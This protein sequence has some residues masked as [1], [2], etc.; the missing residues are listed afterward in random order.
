M[1][2]LDGEKLAMMRF[3][4]ELTQ[5]ELSVR[6]GC[7]PQY[8][9]HCECAENGSE[10]GIDFLFRLA[11]ALQCDPREL[12]SDTESLSTTPAP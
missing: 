5:R 8:I 10:S 9:S 7:S 11:V 3:K 6:A 4:R 1:Y 2:V 12:V